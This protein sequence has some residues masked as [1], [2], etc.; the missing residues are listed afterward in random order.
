MDTEKQIDADA[1]IT[2]PIP[3]T[4]AWGLEDHEMPAPPTSAEQ[5]VIDEAIGPMDSAMPTEHVPD[6]SQGSEVDL[7]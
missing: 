6:I 2:K 7:G 1:D 4:D 3:N 5:Q